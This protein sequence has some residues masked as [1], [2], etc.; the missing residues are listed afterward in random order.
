M[1]QCVNDSL[2]IEIRFKPQ[3][4]DNILLPG[5]LE[6]LEALLPELILAMMQAEAMNDAA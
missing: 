2:D 4:A 5:E 1:P 6:L 3:A